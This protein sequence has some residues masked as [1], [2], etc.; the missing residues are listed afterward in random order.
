MRFVFLDEGGIS[1]HEP[2]A[3]VAGIVVHADEQLVPLERE[4]ARLRRKHIPEGLRDDFVFHTKEIWSGTGKIFGDRDRWTLD[5]RLHILRDLIRVIKKIDV[6]VVHEAYERQSILENVSPDEKQPTDREV[7]IAAHACAFAACTLRVEQ[8]MRKCFPTE[9]AQIVAEDNDQARTMLKS[10]HDSFR[11]PHRAPGIIPNTILPFRHIRS[12]VHFADKK[13]SAPLQL[14]DLCA[15][16]IRGRLSK[17]PKGNNLYGRLKSM[18]F[19]FA[20]ADENYR[21]PL[22]GVSPPYKSVAYEEVDLDLDP[23]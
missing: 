4:L 1:S 16:I 3:V 18:L 12:S 11:F 15:F 2:I 9:V 6:P 14:A 22:I 17:H 7:N 20:D 5:R 10:V 8:Y 23:L 19:K 21:G 13:E